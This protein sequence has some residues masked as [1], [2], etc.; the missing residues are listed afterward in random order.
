MAIASRFFDPHG[1]RYFGL[2][3]GFWRDVTGPEPFPI[4]PYSRDWGDSGPCEVLAEGARR[5]MP[6]I[7]PADA[8]PGALILFRM[9]ARAMAKHVG[10]LTGPD[11]FLHAYEW[12]GVIEERLTPTWRQRIAFALLF[13]QC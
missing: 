13:P 11:I 1:H 3:L 12:L 5:M 8:P 10:I 7:A 4:Q 9:M 2:V 6:E